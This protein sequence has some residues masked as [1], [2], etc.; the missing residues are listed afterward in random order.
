[1]R[2]ILLLTLLFAISYTTYAASRETAD[3]NSMDPKI[4]DCHDTLPVFPG[5]TH[6]LVYYL[7]K[8]IKYPVVA[9]EKG[10][11]GRVLVRFTID[12]D[13]AVIR[14]SVVRSVD[15]LLDAEAIRVISS[16]PKWIPGRV[17]GKYT[18]FL[19]VCPFNFKLTKTN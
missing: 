16:M 2:K 18:Q 11:Q 4:F 9:T 17:N 1:M 8:N 19:Y 3:D 5:G 12:K 13:G 7:S 6:N 10:I 15:P 14:P